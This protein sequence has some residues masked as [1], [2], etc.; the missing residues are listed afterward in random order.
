MSCAFHH[1]IKPR[2]RKQL[3]AGILKANMVSSRQ[4]EN[5]RGDRM[6]PAGGHQE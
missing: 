3:Y 5:N 4:Y 6:N 1:I 2:R